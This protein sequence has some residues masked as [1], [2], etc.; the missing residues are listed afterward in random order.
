MNIPFT[1]DLG[2]RVIEGGREEGIRKGCLEKMRRMSRRKRKM[3]IR[4][5]WEETN[6]RGEEGI[7]S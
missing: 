6:K 1:L 5:S 4:G 3:I 7:E 2:I